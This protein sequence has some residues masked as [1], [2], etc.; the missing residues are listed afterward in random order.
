MA[1]KGRAYGFIPVS[2][3]WDTDG[4]A[5][6]EAGLLSH[7]LISIMSLFRTGDV[8]VLFDERSDINDTS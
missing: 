4:Y 8:P 2:V 7:A 3:E 6:V 1:D 5:I